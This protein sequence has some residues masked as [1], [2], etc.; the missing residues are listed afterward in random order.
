MS[1][2]PVGSILPFAGEIPSDLEDQGWLA[3]NG[4]EVSRSQYSELYQAIA[5]AF[6]SAG[7]GVFNLP[8]FRGMFQRCYMG[9]APNPQTRDPDAADRSSTALGGNRGNQIG[10]SQLYGT[11][12]AR[13]PFQMDIL[14]CTDRNCDKGCGTVVSTH[15]TGSVTVTSYTG[16]DLETRPVNR[17]VYYIIKYCS[18]VG[19][20]T[21]VPPVG[22][23][24]AYAGAN[25]S[26]IP[27]D[28][29]ICNGA[30]HSSSD[31]DWANWKDLYAAIGNAHG[32]TGT[33]AFN[34][35]DYRGTFLRGVDLQSGRD[36]NATTRTAAAPG[37]N[38]GDRVGSVEA[39][40]TAIPV[41]TSFVT[42]VPHIPTSDGHKDVDGTVKV[43]YKYNAQS[44]N[45]TLTQKGGDAE[46]RPRNYRVRYVIR[47][48]STAAFPVGGVIFAGMASIGEGWHV[49][50]GS[51]LSKTTC[52]DLYGVLGNTYGEDTA[53]FNLPDYRGYFLRGSSDA[54][55]DPTGKVTSP[56]VPVGTY[57]DYAT[58]LPVNPIIG[59]VPHLPV[60]TA[61]GHGETAHDV[62][63]ENGN[64]TV[65]TC[66]SGGDKETRPVNLYVMACIKVSA[67]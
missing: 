14:D 16:G 67:G 10:S 33:N 23:V 31:A 18:T 58:A 26:T 28:W 43:Y 20:Q 30:A 54:V 22:T 48:T 13:N 21:V 66:N 37:G 50:D 61:K 24:I 49:C 59:A 5:S 35:P 55:T 40:A 17:N 27:S 62:G 53:S 42:T 8:D 65:N 3:C 29:A 36:K 64:H 1:E 15:N 63:G 6:G 52:A 38:I 60:E 4:R 47:K 39:A 44:V 2:L 7:T 46:T 12:P 9:D 32:S 34:L 41:T 25:D 45:V 56:A 51:A 57:E 19:G 11:A